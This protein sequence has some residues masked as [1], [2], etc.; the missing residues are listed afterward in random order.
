MPSSRIARLA[1]GLGAAGLLP[2]GAVI[3]ALLAGG[4]SLRFMATVLGFA[5]P[6]LILSFL[7]GVWWGLA[8]RAPERAP[9]WLWVVAV[10]P[11]LIAFAAC[12]PLAAGGCWPV[13][14]LTAVG[15][16]LIGSVAVDF[17]LARMGLCPEGW[18]ALRVPLS[19]GLGSM[20]LLITVL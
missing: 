2:Q 7:G 10:V 19:I 4:S 17:R 9:G 18:M 11:S 8:A 16:S 13:A 15:L 1:Y 6:A 14:S 20:T 5:Y 3:L 12:F